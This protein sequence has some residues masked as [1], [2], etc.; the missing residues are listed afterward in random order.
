MLIMEVYGD[1]IEF[2]RYHVLDKREIA[3][4]RRWI[5]NLPFRREDSV[6]A[7]RRSETRRAPEFADDARLMTRYDY[8]YI[9][10]IFP[11]PVKGDFALLYRVEIAEK[12]EDGSFADPVT[13]PYA[14][15]FYRREKNQTDFIQLKLPGKGM[16]HSTWYRIRVYPVE[17]FGKCGKPLELMEYTWPGYSFRD[18]T[19]LYPQE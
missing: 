8:G 3:P 18:G 4:E 7:A 10:V 14:G 15:D 16:K 11:R 9:F 17:S 1:R 13:I 2:R 6:D 12:R 5:V 19:P